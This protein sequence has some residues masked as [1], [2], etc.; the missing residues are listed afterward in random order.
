LLVVGLIIVATLAV[1]LTLPLGLFVRLGIVLAGIGL[2]VSTTQFGQDAFRLAGAT[3]NTG[4]NARI[5]G[6]TPRPNSQDQ[7]TVTYKVTAT[8]SVD[9]ELR[10][11]F[12][13]QQVWIERNLTFGL[14]AAS[15]TTTRFFG[16][17]VAVPIVD[18]AFLLVTMVGVSGYEGV[19]VSP[20]RDWRREGRTE[21]PSADE[22]LSNAAN[23]SGHCALAPDRLPFMLAVRDTEEPTG[24]V[25]I[26]PTDLSTASSGLSAA[27]GVDIEFVSLEFSRVDGPLQYTLQDKI[28]W[29]DSIEREKYKFGFEVVGLNGRI[30][31]ISRSSISVREGQ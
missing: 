31:T 29:V 9:G 28:R 6:S 19:L 22:T 26:A 3:V 18:D 30:S 12:S 27:F 25:G 5:D 15:D 8:V 17:G 7:V 11:G 16:E 1:A 2:G 20:C 4:P 10:S 14:Q 21:P 23:F 13:L 24:I